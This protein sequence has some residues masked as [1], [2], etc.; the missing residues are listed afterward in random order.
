M[1]PSAGGCLSEMIGPHWLALG[2]SGLARRLMVAT[3]ARSGSTFITAN[4]RSFDAWGG[5][6][7]GPQSGAPRGRYCAQLG[8]VQDD[9]L[10]LIYMRARFYEPGTGRF[11]SEDPSKNGTNCYV[12]GDCNPIGKGDRSGKSGETLDELFLSNYAAVLGPLVAGIFGAVHEATSGSSL[13]RVVLKGAEGAS[14][15]YLT[16]TTVALLANTWSWA[17][18]CCSAD[19]SSGGIGGI[20]ATFAIAVATYLTACILTMDAAC[21]SGEDIAVNSIAPK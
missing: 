18:G 1:P 11:V 20:L 5:I 15:Y 16:A 9:E 2:G 14:D 6:R 8:H 10:G 13:L 7:G 21:I 3:L 19:A 12:Y 4:Q 17:A